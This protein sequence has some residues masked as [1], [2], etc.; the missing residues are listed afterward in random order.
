MC[1]KQTLDN[2]LWWLSIVA[3]PCFLTLLRKEYKEMNLDDVIA[4]KFK[5]QSNENSIKKNL[6]RSSV[7]KWPSIHRKVSKLCYIPWSL[8]QPYISSFVHACPF[9]FHCFGIILTYRANMGGSN[10]SYWV[11]LPLGPSS[12]Y[13]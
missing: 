2:R 6:A 10:N 11:F 8:G 3:S 9:F 4:S 7:W 5:K 1:I 12:I 13:N